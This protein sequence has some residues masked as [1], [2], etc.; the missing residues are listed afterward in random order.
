M[1]DLKTKAPRPQGTKD[2]NPRG[3]TLIPPPERRSADTLSIAY[4]L[5]LIF[6]IPKQ[7]SIR[8]TLYIPLP[9]NGGVSGI[10][11]SHEL[12]V[13]DSQLHSPAAHGRTFTSSGSLY[14]RF[15]GY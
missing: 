10:V 9:G 11:Y 7:Q 13:C 14:T 1:H 3:T 8:N 15:A 4:F 2:K 6:Y 5:L 12:S